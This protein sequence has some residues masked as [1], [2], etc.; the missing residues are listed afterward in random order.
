MLVLPRV[1][2]LP[3]EMWRVSEGTLLW[4]EVPGKGLVQTRGVV[5]EEGLEVEREEDGKKKEK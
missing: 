5:Q 4:T 2:H 3:A 1:R